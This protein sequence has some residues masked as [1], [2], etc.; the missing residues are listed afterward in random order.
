M[1][2]GQR[3]GPVVEGRAHQPISAAAASAPPA[4]PPS[5]AMLA[6]AAVHPPRSAPASP[7]QPW[8]TPPPCPVRQRA[9]A[10]ALAVR[11]DVPAPV[12]RE[13][14]VHATDARVSRRLCRWTRKPRVR[15]LHCVLRWD[16]RP[17]GYMWV[18]EMRC[19][20][21]RGGDSMGRASKATAEKTYVRIRRQLTLWWTGERG[22]TRPERKHMRRPFF[23]KQCLNHRAKST[24]G[25]LTEWNRHK[26]TWYL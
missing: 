5:T 20:Q 22:R 6:A 25:N 1:F 16:V 18:L 23:M 12:Q 10:P 26:T 7:R 9:P 17:S 13:M 8:G 2:E 4:P 24:A 11:F 14:D 15:R 3:V 19:G 21:T